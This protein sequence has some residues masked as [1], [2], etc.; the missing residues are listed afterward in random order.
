MPAEYAEGVNAVIEHSPQRAWWLRAALVLQSPQPVFAALRD[1][2]DEEVY[3][4]QEPVVAIACLAGIAGVLATPLA[5]RFLDSP[6]GGLLAVAAWA[7][8]AGGAYALAAVWVGGF[9]LAWAT[10][11]LGGRGSHRRARHV[12][13][14]ALAPVA[15]SLLLVWP[16]RLAVYGSDVFRSG[17]TD[18]G[19][20]A[21]GLGA[22]EVGFVAW[23]AALLV[24]GVRT[25]HGWT[26]GRA[27]GA[28]AIAAGLPALLVLVELLR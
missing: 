1:D 7:V 13:G 22:I 11:R 18:H 5:G 10:R 20:G 14:F 27:C 6:G 23:S 4:R 28:V 15:L 2:S 24:I 8:F 21:T 3:A 17:G 26:W 9:L 19:A 12:L 25:V 16:V